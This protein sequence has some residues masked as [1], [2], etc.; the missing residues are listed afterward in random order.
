MWIAISKFGISRPYFQPSGGA[1]NAE[2]Y[3]K[4]CINKRLVPYLRTTL[5]GEPN[6]FRPDLA[7]AHYACQTQDK[8]CELGVSFVPSR[9]TLRTF[10]NSVRLSNFGFSSKQKCTE[11][12]GKQTLP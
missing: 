3:T 12:V 2:V 9:S 4:E 1:I 10:P 11:V 5:H 7:T 8:L 6:L